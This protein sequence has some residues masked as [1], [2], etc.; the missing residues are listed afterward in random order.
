MALRPLF[1]AFLQLGHTRATSPD[2]SFFSSAKLTVTKDFNEYPC[3]FDGDDAGQIGF[4]LIGFV[5]SVPL[6]VDG[7][8]DG[9][10]NDGSCDFDDSFYAK[11]KIV[12]PH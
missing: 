3:L 9:I 2:L 1:N 10:Q 6:S 7:V 5:A 8:K 4:S 11:T 12:S